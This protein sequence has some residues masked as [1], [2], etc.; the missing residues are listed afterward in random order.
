MG[1]SFVTG[2]KVGRDLCRAL[3]LEQVRSLSLHFRMDEV[4]T[5]DVE[6]IVSEP[7]A[8]IIL[9]EMKKYKLVP[10]EDE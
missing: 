5:A 7:S 1:T 10:M 6:M 3:G 4:V 9:T 8:E 2:W